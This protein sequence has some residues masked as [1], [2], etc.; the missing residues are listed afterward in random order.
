MERYNIARALSCHTR[1]EFNKTGHQV[2]VRQFMADTALVAI[3][4]VQLNV[5]TA[6]AIYAAHKF[7]ERR[8]E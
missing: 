8:N 1:V 6:G 2:G 7:C 5:L 4:F 3:S